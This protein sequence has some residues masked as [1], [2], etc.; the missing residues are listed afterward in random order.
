MGWKKQ[1]ALLKPSR[2]SSRIQRLQEERKHTAWKELRVDK[3][4]KTHP[5]CV[6]ELGPQCLGMADASQ[7]FEG[8]DNGDLLPVGFSPRA[9]S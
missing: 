2:G 9:S 1:R 7:T 6:V 8:S 3:P 4:L 5:N